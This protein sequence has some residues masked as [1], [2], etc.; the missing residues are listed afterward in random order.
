MLGIGMSDND[1]DA[2]LIGICCCHRV[3]LYRQPCGRVS[4]GVGIYEAM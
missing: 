1:C 2:V 3:A 4:R